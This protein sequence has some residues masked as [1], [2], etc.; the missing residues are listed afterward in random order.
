MR[1]L[2]FHHVHGMTI[3]PPNS[4]MNV[5]IFDKIAELVVRI[6]LNAALNDMHRLDCRVELRSM[7]FWL[8]GHDCRDL[9]SE[10]HLR[11]CFT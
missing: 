3:G 11:V 1:R 2:F 10:S 9:R 7:Y 6:R 5:N 8:G 4:H